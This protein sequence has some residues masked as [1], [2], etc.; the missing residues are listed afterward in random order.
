M[1]IAFDVDNVLA[2]SMSFWCRKATKY[3]GRVVTKEEI[4]SHKIVGSVSMSPPE[5]FRLQN[6]VWV[7]W[8]NLRAT[9]RFLSQKLGLFRENGF[10][11]VIATSRP[12]RSIN[13]VKK[14]L[15]WQKIPYDEFIALGPYRP[16][17]EIETDVL[18]DD[19][20]DQIREFVRIGKTGFLYTQPWNKNIEV[21]RAILVKSIDD[22]LKFYG[23]SD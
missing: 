21:K 17:S 6:E 23:L 20:P 1:K 8:R 16:K 10:H 4:T 11:V 19:A 14:W 3:L 22:V 18:V 12:L 5:I 2:D 13:L 9:E 7:E 15:A